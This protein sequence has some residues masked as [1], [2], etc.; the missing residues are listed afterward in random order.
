MEGGG[1]DGGGRGGGGERGKWGKEDKKK[2]TLT[3]GQ[4]RINVCLD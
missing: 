2:V 3:Q 4:V 1:E